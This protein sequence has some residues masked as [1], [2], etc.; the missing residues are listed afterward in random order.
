MLC[1]YNSFSPRFY[2]IGLIKCLI[3]RAYKL[4]NTWP[5]CHDDVSKIKD[6]LKRNPYPPFT[7]DKIIK[8]YIDK[9]HY[10]N[11]LLKQHLETC[12][13]FITRIEEHIKKDKKS[14]VFQ[15]LH[16]REECFSSFD[17]NCFSILDSA[18]TKYQTQLKEGIY[19]DW[20][21]PNLNKQKNHLST[22]LSI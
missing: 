10:N 20:E 21:K 2:K 4:N 22:P 16:C 18:R 6:I 1:N 14:H 9:I 19:I 5:G 12:R 3:D 7:L 17:L 11:I 8:A 13:H 15:H